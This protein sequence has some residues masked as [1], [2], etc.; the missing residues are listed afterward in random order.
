MNYSKRHILPVWSLVVAAS[1][2]MSGAQLSALATEPMHKHA[3]RATCT[4]CHG[5]APKSI[6]VESAACL[7][8]HGSYK[9]IA[10]RTA[11]DE[12]PKKFLTANPHAAHTGELRCS[13]CHHEHKASEVY[14]DKCHN[15]KVEMQVVP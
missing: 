9:E 10:A 13:L 1:L 7:K 6:A 4:D 5:N 8:C 12:N 14:C 11:S 15:P 3:D 2:F